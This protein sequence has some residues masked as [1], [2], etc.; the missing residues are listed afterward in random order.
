MRVPLSWLR[1]FTP[2]EEPPE[3]LAHALSFLGLVVEGT[4]VVPAPFGG[5]VVARVL[6]TRPHPG[7]DRVQLVDVDAGEG[8]AR[9]VVCGAFNMKA[10]DLVP[11]ADVGAVMPNGMEI[12][13]RRVRGEWSN[14][15]LCSAPEL[16]IG[17]EGGE[18]AIF[19][20]P[21]GSAKPGQSAAEALG[22]GADIVFD[23]E[24][25]PNRGDCLSVVGVA[26]DLAA[27]LGLPFSVPAPPH[28]VAEDV[29]AAAVAIDPAAEDR[30]PRF[31]GTVVENVK[32]ALVSP[33]VRRRLALAGMRPIN[34]VVD[35]S[36]YVMLELGQPNHP[37]DISRLGGGGLVVRPA[38]AGERLVTLDGTE[39][40]LGPDDIVIS[41]AEGRAVGLAG[42][43]GG[44]DAE[45]SPETTTVLLEVANFAP[46]TI[47]ETGKRLGLLSEARTRFER[48]V[49]PGLPPAAVDRFVELLGSGVRR[50]E[51][52]DL[53]PR[54]AAPLEVPLRA[55]RANLV[56]G[57][58]LS[59][60]DCAGLLSRLGF[61]AN[62]RA[63]E[64][65]VFRVPTWRPDCTREVDLIEEVARIYGYDKLR[66]LLP[67]RPARPSRLAGWQLARRQVREV[68]A[69]TGA[70]EAWSST[71]LSGRE[72][73]LAGLSPS[74]A[75][76]VENPLDTSQALLRTSL[77]PGLLRALRSNR[78]RQAGALSL[79]EIGNVFAVPGG[80]S[81]D[82]VGSGGPEA[83][84]LASLASG[85]GHEGQS[86]AGA[87]LGGF[88]YRAVEGVVEWEQLGLVALGAGVDATYAARA[89]EVI[90]G[91]LRVDGAAVV[92][93]AADLGPGALMGLPALHAGRRAVLA[94]GGRPVGVV[95]ELAPEVAARN[96]LAGRVAVLLADLGPLL[97]APPRPLV[98]R[99]VSR[100]PAVDL[101]LALSVA[102]V[103]PA[104][105]VAATVR[106]AAG[107]LAEEVVLFEVWRDR[108]LGEGRRSLNF[109]ARLRADDR[110][111]TEADVGEV[112]ERVA[113]A[114]A[115]R[116][117]AELR[118]AAPTS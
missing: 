34:A 118:G 73:E 86:R 53:R 58:S 1:E 37:Y 65:W 19:V 101:D 70:S 41:D 97:S 114:T 66:R 9:Q 28:V 10:G 7:A 104:G 78:E 14:G 117:G 82:L 4:E 72:L 100:Y 74:P 110:T 30:C 93:A 23:L 5:I 3:R 96:G 69:G 107:D 33:L 40:Q 90:A 115:E 84:F 21:P 24:I 59:P 47:A 49:D 102:D 39:R 71:F 43:M 20:L 94:V 56:L 46:L 57:T 27:G 11:L 51:T 63:D 111:L 68:L 54:R 62:Q 32:A 42:I 87:S 108:S 85:D 26:R 76:V 75:V 92:P 106:Q 31:T 36:N 48:G 60:E 18:P 116:H 112:R 52:T 29:P 80:P 98:A 91:A 103:V 16:G 45:I 25:S 99:E 13:R 17:P 22:F 105:E 15:M 2:V 79:F 6:A 109:R 89:W 77:L 44:A 50:G 67:A 88:F 113:A 12:G 83:T 95:G 81:G 38:R 55:R 8:E 61:E 64:G 35:A